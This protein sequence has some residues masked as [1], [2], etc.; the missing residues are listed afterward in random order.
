MC[1]LF[2]GISQKPQRKEKFMSLEVLG[3][4]QKPQGKQS[5]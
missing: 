3:I 1:L 4:R 5:L 2:L